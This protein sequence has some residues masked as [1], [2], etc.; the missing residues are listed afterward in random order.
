MKKTL[1]V[2]ES[3]Y[4]GT[5][6]EQDDAVLWFTHALRNAGSEMTVL[7]CGNAVNYTVSGQNPRGLV[8]GHIPIERPPH[9]DRD[10]EAMVEAG[11][12]VFVVRDDVEKRGIDPEKV[13]GCFEM[14]DRSRV[15][16][17][18]SRFD[19]IWHW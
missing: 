7:L 15:A 16:H 3:A 2:V 1:C 8:I 6:E 12:A 10:L 9:P 14:I 13:V 17:L 18:F 11:I 4:R 5:Q 19:Q